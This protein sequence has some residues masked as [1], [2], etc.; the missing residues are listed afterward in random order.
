ML[1]VDDVELTFGRA[2]D[3]RRL[4]A[5]PVEFSKDPADQGEGTLGKASLVALV[6]PEIARVHHLEHGHCR[7]G[8][9]A[10]GFGDVEGGDPAEGCGH[11][12][13]PLF[14]R[15]VIPSMNMKRAHEMRKAEC[16]S[17]LGHEKGI[18]AA[19]AGGRRLRSC[20]SHP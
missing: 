16:L 10:I 14:R 3:D 20:W 4:E 11:R 5:A 9:S 13:T 6:D 19:E 17:R 12:E 7:I 1:A 18:S 15:G 2:G 8:K